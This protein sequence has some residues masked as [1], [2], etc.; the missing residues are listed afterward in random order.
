M[1]TKP[2]KKADSTE[3]TAPAEEK[4]ASRKRRGAGVVK[5]TVELSEN[6]FKQMQLAY[7]QARAF[8]GTLTRSQFRS[9]LVSNAV[10]AKLT[11]MKNAAPF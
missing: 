8:N 10:G 4:K 11:A 1:A 6:D 2:A 9:S 5:I 3:E 7:K